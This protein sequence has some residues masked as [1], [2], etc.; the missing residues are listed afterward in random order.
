MAY[1]VYAIVYG[2][3]DPPEVM[4]LYASR[5][6]AEKDIGQFKG[7][8]VEIIP[9]KVWETSDVSSLEINDSQK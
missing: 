1:E 3:Y 5:E 8:M 2:N 4:S 7:T 9:M 6:M